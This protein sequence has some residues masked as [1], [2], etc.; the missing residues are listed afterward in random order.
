MG[1]CNIKLCE[2]I[3]YLSSNTTHRLNTVNTEAN[4]QT[5][6]WISPVLT[7]YPLNTDLT[8]PNFFLDL[9][10]VYF[11]EV[12]SPNSEYIFAYIWAERTN[13][14]TNEWMNE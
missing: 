3:N 7:M 10:V 2:T 14:R 6:L 9:Q 4:Q 5:K 8:I 12:S 1:L 13:E 11:Q